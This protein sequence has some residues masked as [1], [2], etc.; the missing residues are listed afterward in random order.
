M[1]VN[2]LISNYYCEIMHEQNTIIKTMLIMACS[3]WLVH[4]PNTLIR[5]YQRRHCAIVI[6]LINI[7]IK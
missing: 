2:P 7:L 4:R 6:N 3:S 1:D 5:S